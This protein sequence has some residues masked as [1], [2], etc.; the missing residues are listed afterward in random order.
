VAQGTTLKNIMQ[1]LFRKTF[2]NLLERC[3]SL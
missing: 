2:V 1:V 3:L